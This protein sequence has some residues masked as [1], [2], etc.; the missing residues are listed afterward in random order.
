MLKGEANARRNA[1]GL[2]GE[3]TSPWSA[4]DAF[5]LGAPRRQGRT[6]LVDGV[7]TKVEVAW[8]AD[9]P[10]VSVLGEPPAAS[11]GP[12]PMV[13]TV[14][15]SAPV[16]VLSNMRQVV[17]DWPSYAVGAGEAGDGGGVHAPIVGRLAKVFVRQGDTV[18]KG[19]RVAVVEAMKM[20]HVLHAPRA[21]RIDKLAARE[22]DQVAEG[23]LIAVLAEE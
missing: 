13:I 6:V 4:Q 8:T 20:E 23:A 10:D 15:D 1:S 3:V 16:Y 2:P 7:A 18:A 5:Q 17:L 22:G 12:P 11:A 19:D 21:G 14:G 9:G